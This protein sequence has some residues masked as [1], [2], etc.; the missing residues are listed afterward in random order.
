MEEFIQKFKQMKE[1]C[2]VSE[3]RELQ[4]EN[5]LNLTKS[6]LFPLRKEVA[7]LS[8]E[9][10]MLRMESL[11][12]RDKELIDG[13]EQNEISKTLKKEVSSLEEIC[14]L[15]DEQNKKLQIQID[16]LNKV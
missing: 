7:K 9:N 13:E 11:K 2:I 1:L 12:F 10:H 5:D 4:L 14:K 3:Q 8:K 6:Q 16:T 15:K